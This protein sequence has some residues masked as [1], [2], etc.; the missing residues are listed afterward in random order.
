MHLGCV[1]SKVNHS[2]F[3]YSSKKKSIFLLLVS[4]II[5]KNLL[6]VNTL[7]KSCYPNC[8]LNTT[9]L[10]DPN[11]HTTVFLSY[12]EPNSDINYQHLLELCPNAKRVH[13]IKG[14]DTAHKTVATLSDTDSVII[15]DGDNRVKSDFYQQTYD[16]G[17]IDISNNVISFTSNNIV[18]G[19]QYGN[20]GIKVWPV[21]LLK[22]MNTHENSNNESTVVDFDFSYYRQYNVVA[23]D[24]HINSSPLQAW[25]AGFREGIKLLLDDGQYKRDINTIDWRNF[26]RLWNWMHVGSDVENGLWAIHGARTGCLFGIKKYTLDKIHDFDHLNKLFRNA[27]S[28][29]KNCLLEQ[30]NKLGEEIVGLTK[31]KRITNVYSVEDSKNYRE[32]IKPI[33]RCPDNKPYDIVFISYNE[34]NSD[35]NF[36]KLKTRF[37]RAF[38]L[39]GVKGIHQAHIEAAKLCSTDYFYVVDGDAEIVD[40]FNFDYVVPFYDTFKVRVYRAKNPVNDLIYGYG[41][42]KLLPRIATIH[43]NT[44]KPDMTTSICNS[45][46]PIN[47]ISNI[48]RFNT[49]PFN[50]WRS[51]FRECAKLASQ[52]IANQITDETN[53]RLEIWCTV[54]NDQFVLDGANHGREFGKRNKNDLAKLLLINDFEWIKKEYDRFYKN[55][56]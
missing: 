33:L 10:F 9:M 37:P 53:K 27:H 34:E 40:D 25:R 5:H 43:M 54:G 11:N 24:I 21:K 44:D 15:I 52:V 1:T 56:I 48:T 2:V 6:F 16:L 13:G 14:S 41:G 31:N 18:N 12:D 28:I 19:Q 22:S 47:I 17:D 50:S 3:I 39:S 49:G 55:T 8:S 42:I 29:A 36:N 26:E 51:A 30:C 20:G 35:I 45:Y 46:E 7:K 38:R 23:S 32:T 4:S